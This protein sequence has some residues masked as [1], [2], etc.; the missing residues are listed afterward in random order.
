MS[1]YFNLDGTVGDTT[2]SLG[3]GGLDSSASSGGGLTSSQG[4]GLAGMGISAL[5]SIMSSMAETEAFKDKMEAITQAKIAT[6]KQAVTS[7]E[8]EQVKNA[9]QIQELDEV[10]GDKLSQR[11]LQ[12]IKNQARLK[13]AAAE[14]G[15]SGGTTDDAI[16]E[17]F[18]VEHFDR[19]NMISSSKQRKRSVMRSMEA[20]GVR[21][22]K[23]LQGITSGG[24]QITSNSLLAGASS[25]V[26]ILMSGLSFASEEDK[27]SLFG[28]LGNGE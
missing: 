12:G 14:T 18:M 7:Y 17:A 19:A 26:D 20:A 2:M 16:M 6:M 3:Q 24:T 8:F 1:T 10:L 25:G 9:E 4:A 15:T 11:A 28:I 5:G 13:A 21:L 27:S 23:E 22:G